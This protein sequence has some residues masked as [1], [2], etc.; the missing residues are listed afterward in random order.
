MRNFLIAVLLA[1]AFIFVSC[2]DSDTKNSGDTGDTSDTGGDTG[3]TGDTGN[4]GDAG[5]TVSDDDIADTGNTGNTG[6]TNDTGNTASDNDT[7]DTGSG[8][9]ATCTDS[10]KFCHTHEGLDWSDVSS[11]TMMR[12]EAIEYCENIGGRLPTISELRTLVQSCPATETGG[13]CGI[14]DICSAYY[15][16]WNN[17]CEGCEDDSFG[18]YSVFGNVGWFWSSSVRSDTQDL[19]LVWILGFYN[20][21]L[22]EAETCCNYV[23]CVR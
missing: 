13:E 3:D 16:C 19:D 20:G 22:D 12:D 14:T 23:R 10:E 7:A 17:S 11:K 2:E 4:T 15:D 6:N 9:S 8:V 1:S 18:K 5:N 21:R